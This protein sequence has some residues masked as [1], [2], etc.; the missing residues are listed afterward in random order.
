M[1]IFD[2]S[3]N[4]WNANQSWN[5]D[6]IGVVSGLVS[7][8]RFRVKIRRNAYNEQSSAAGYIYDTRQSKWNAIVSF[9]IENCDCNH[10]SYTNNNVSS[11]DFWKD[12][13]ML[14]DAMVKICLGGSFSE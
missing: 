14:L 8:R 13:A 9:P 3:E 1:E 5:Y 4:C 6:W 2:I 11:V 10:L 7:G 12:R